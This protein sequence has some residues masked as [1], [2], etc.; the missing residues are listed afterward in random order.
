MTTTP[1][2]CSHCG[3]PVPAGL[4]E[5][6]SEHQFC[7]SGCRLAFDV[8][9]GSGLDQ[10]YR[11]KE[12]VDEPGRPA[13]SSG[14][15]YQ[16]F[17]D[18][19]FMS[20]YGRTTS[21]G[22]TTIELYL[23]GV[24]CAACVWLVEKTPVVIPGVAECRLDIGR[25]LATVVWNPDTT[26]LSDVARFLD[27]IGYPCH[28]FRGVE[29]REIELRADRSFLVRI[30]VAGAVAGNIMLLA[31]ALYG[32]A[33]HGIEAR[34]EQLFRWVSMVL[35]LPSVLWCA[36]VFYRGAWGSL[37]TRTLHMDVPISVGILAGFGWGASTPSA[38]GAKSISIRSR[39]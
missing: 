39:C 30:A 32:G 9:Q 25:S 22:L 37:K 16:E 29:A 34:Y 18:P 8:I 35:S 28:P 15:R 12:R 10:F 17:D 13:A 4:V 27:S 1:I 7:C 33:F 11:I 3:L 14:R 5:P 19:S 38:A 20:L 23:E 21:E 26:R 31:F 6:Q 36:N 2:D 24:H